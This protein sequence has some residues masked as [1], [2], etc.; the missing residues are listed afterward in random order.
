MATG[1]L[2]ALSADLVR[3]LFD[4]DQST[5]LLIRRT[6]RGSRALT[7]APAGSIDAHG[8]RQ[9]QIARRLY[10]AHRLIWLHVHGE[11]PNQQIDHVNGDRSDNRIGNLREASNQQN[12]HNTVRTFGVTASGFRGV[13]RHEPGLWRARI[14]VNGRTKHLGLFS[15]P[16]QASAAYL[17][18][19]SESHPFWVGAAT[20]EGD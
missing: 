20:H 16:Q 13:S 9:I 1:P 15:T 5:G 10:K 3:E 12:C 2:T 18:A 19:K 6:R 11:W 7:G 8:Y 17:A 4:Y 14:S